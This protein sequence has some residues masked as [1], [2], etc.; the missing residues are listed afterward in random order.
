MSPAVTQRENSCWSAAWLEHLPVFEAWLAGDLESALA[1][2]RAVTAR[3]PAQTSY[4]RDALATTNGHFWLTLGR[5]ED[6]RAAFE[7]VGHVGQREANLSHI[8]DLVDDRA[9]VVAHLE[10][11]GWAHSA[12][13]FAL[14]GLLDRANQILRQGTA[15]EPERLLVGGLESLAAG[16]LPEGA[17]LLQQAV[18]LWRGSPNRYFYSASLALGDAWSAAGQPLQAIRVFEEAAA[19]RPAYAPPG[20]QAG[21]WIKVQA[22]LVQEYRRAGRSR[23]AG[24]LEQK[25][26]RLLAHAD[27]DYPWLA[28]LV[29]PGSS[30]TGPPAVH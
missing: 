2:Q 6:A 25:V 19:E 24:L 26:R 29:P 13:A 7:L 22:R 28:A 1:A 11:V 30:Q 10:R 16:R 21:W 18:D 12:A 5:L 4:L 15:S 17:S 20:L 8:A 9:Q 14:A 27:P 23:E 3:L